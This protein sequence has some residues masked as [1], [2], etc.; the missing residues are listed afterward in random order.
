[1][2]WK[3]LA[4]LLDVSE[5]T[6]RNDWRRGRSTIPNSRF[7]KLKELVPK[8][9]FHEFETL[10]K[11]WGQS[12]GGK[13]TACKLPKIKIPLSGSKNLAE[14]FGAMLGDGCIYSNGQSLVIAGN[15]K[16]DVDYINYL[17]RL[18]LDL[19]AVQPK[20]YNKSG[21]LRLIVNNKRICDFF[22]QMGFNKGRKKDSNIKIPSIF[23]DDG[24]LLILCL[25]GLFDTDGGVYSHPNCGIML[26]IT[27]K[28]PS[29]LNSIKIAFNQLNF[30]VGLTTNRIQLFG[31]KKVNA[32]FTFIGSSNPR[33]FIKL[34]NFKSK[35]YVPSTKQMERLLKHNG[36]PVKINGLMV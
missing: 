1:M 31:F 25:R 4:R 5:H 30:E 9:N 22:E 23:F 2:S 34:Q 8:F 12:M 10:S 17:K 20:I 14:L 29:L 26:D 33:N 27:S 15:Y 11:N 13:N 6:I 36:K 35:S 7:N 16:L 24:R 28:I 21:S 32:F 19:F 18:F 3:D